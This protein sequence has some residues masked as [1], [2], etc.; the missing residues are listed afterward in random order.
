MKQGHDTGTISSILSV[1]FSAY[2]IERWHYR[3]VPT[4]SERRPGGGIQLVNRILNTGFMTLAVAVC[5][6]PLKF[7]QG[8]EGR[9]NCGAG[10]PVR[11]GPPGPALRQRNQPYPSAGSRRG[12]RLRTGGPPH[13]KY[14]LRGG[15]KLKWYWAFGLLHD[16]GEVGVFACAH[17]SSLRVRYISVPSRSICRTSGS[18]TFS[19]S[20]APRSASS[21]ET[22]VVLTL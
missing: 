20:T 4:A 19:A 18:A 7:P 17:Y 2:W 6:I 5:P 12:R 16:P 15:R 11:A 10:S 9:R 8:W 14:R 21:E 22:G 13:K 3:L 1:I